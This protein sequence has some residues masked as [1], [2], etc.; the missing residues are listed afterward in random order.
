[1]DISE[2]LILF[3]L[4][5]QEAMIYMLLCSNP[6]LSGYEV[7][8]KTGISRSNAYTALAGLVEKGAAYL[9]EDS[10]KR[11]ISVAPEE[12]CENR[13]KAMT[14]AKQ[15]IC[16]NM[17]MTTPKKDEYITIKGETAIIN[18]IK[19]MINAA[20]KRMYLSCSKK[21]LDSVEGELKEAVKKGL[22]V[23]LITEEE[24]DIE[25]I[26]EY[27]NKDSIKGMRLIIDSKTA[28][29]GE[30]KNGAYS[31]A[32]YSGKENLVELL[33]DSMKNEIKLLEFYKGER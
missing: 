16:E 27:I 24:S 18:K 26:L 7:A 31:T 5:R 33:K 32:L 22:K 3:G 2:K 30:T 8:K 23:V 19:T 9:I 1:M 14:K 12:F 10:A 21:T 25:G 15:F 17:Q 28:L 11:Y 29:T 6:A 4:T 20:E 13:I